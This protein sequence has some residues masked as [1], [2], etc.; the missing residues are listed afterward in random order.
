MK[1]RKNYL[2]LELDATMEIYRC[3]KLNMKEIEPYQE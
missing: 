1:V 2:P 3:V